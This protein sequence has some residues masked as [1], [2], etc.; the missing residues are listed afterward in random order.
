M[1]VEMV[2]WGIME[3]MVQFNVDNRYMKTRISVTA[4][5]SIRRNLA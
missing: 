2:I 3:I 4:D 5:M 1:A